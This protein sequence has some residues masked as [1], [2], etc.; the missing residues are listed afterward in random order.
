VNR[1]NETFDSQRRFLSRQQTQ[2][3]IS[4]ICLGSPGVDSVTTTVSRFEGFLEE[5]RKK[6]EA[7]TKRTPLQSFLFEGGQKHA[8]LL[9]KVF[10]RE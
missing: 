4:P 2:A 3:A 5:E 1:Y 9:P 8:F 10:Q 6:L 7:R